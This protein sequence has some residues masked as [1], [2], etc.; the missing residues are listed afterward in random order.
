MNVTHFTT[1]MTAPAS[2]GAAL[3]AS[4]LIQT[5]AVLFVGL[6]I[7]WMLRRRGAAVRSDWYRILLVAGLLAPCARATVGLGAPRVHLPIAFFD[8]VIPTAGEPSIAATSVASRPS[9]TAENPSANRS[10]NLG[11]SNERALIVSARAENSAG[12]VPI[13]S[14]DVN[15]PTPSTSAASG[16]ASS[17]FNLTVVAFYTVWILLS[18]ILVW[19]FGWS[20]IGAMR[21]IRAGTD[22][23][24]ELAD[25]C[26]RLARALRVQPP[27]LARSPFVTGACVFGWRRPMIL[28]SETE[29]GTND[30]VLIHELAHIAR[31]DCLWK[32]LAEFAAALFWFQPLLWRLKSR[33]QE[34]AEEVCDDYVIQFG[35]ERCD[36]ADRLT[37][38]AERF[39]PRTTPVGIGV[40]SFRSSLGHRVT[41][42][43]DSKRELQTRTGRK[44]IA[45][46]LCG[47]V[48]VVLAVSLIDVGR[49]PNRAA[50]AATD[51][52]PS[53][54]STGPN[55]LIPAKEEHGDVV[56]VRGQVLQ[57]DGRPAVGA[58]VSAIWNVDTSEVEYR[59]IATVTTSPSGLFEL[60]YRK[61]QLGK[62]PDRVDAWT[63]TVLEVKAEGC[64]VE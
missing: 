42:I 20:M 35:A 61:S 2:L 46:L 10:T 38:L 28:L 58:K 11:T 64:G 50:G 23:E 24:P 54:A 57:A 36:Y 52:V 7:A 62:I 19:R 41:R 1:D 3:V 48:A 25:R 40:V 18:A 14:V 30:D 22:A 5:T 33:I 6:V 4:I 56:T 43:L 29:A 31:N 37:R 60:V 21:L 13:Q 26:R 47:A 49:P 27:G 39:V 59:P 55:K 16:R 8:R 12:G 9:E 44:T 63:K 53:S 15:Q 45:G 32:L 51:D 17:W 34:C